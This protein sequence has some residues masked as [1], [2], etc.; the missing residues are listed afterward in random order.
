MFDIRLAADSSAAAQARQRVRSLPL[1]GETIEIVSLL[2]TELVTNALRHGDAP[3]SGSQI[4]V[5]VATDNGVVRVDVSNPGNGFTW[6]RSA[7]AALEEPGGLGLVLVDKLADRWGVD[8][9][10]ETH[11]WLEVDRP[12]T[13]PTRA[14]LAFSAPGRPATRSAR[15]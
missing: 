14:A 8:G 13:R 9:G 11:V 4:D 7:A 6:K 1:D 2:V 12:L 5:H 10:D 15:A 3:A